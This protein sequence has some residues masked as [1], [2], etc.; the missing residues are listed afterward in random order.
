MSM[1]DAIAKRR[2][3]HAKLKNAITVQ[4]EFLDESRVVRFVILPNG[5]KALSGKK[6]MN[7]KLGK[8]RSMDLLDP[9]AM[10]MYPILRIEPGRELEETAID[11]RRSSRP[12]HSD[13]SPNGFNIYDDGNWC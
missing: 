8:D 6:E 5:K 4:E 9:C 3:E 13:L 11:A 1:D 12:R 7:M 2:Y 10:R